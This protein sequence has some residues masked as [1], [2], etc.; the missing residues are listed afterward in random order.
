M[1]VCIYVKTTFRLIESVLSYVLSSSA[2]Y[3]TIPWFVLKYY[4]WSV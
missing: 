1:Y 3:A 4:A 2:S